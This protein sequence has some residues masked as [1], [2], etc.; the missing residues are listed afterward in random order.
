MMV[1]GWLVGGYILLAFVVANLGWLI[2]LGR[3]LGG[4][5]PAIRLLVW[6]VGLL[7]MA[8]LGRLLEARVT[9]SV[10][11]QGWEFYAVGALLFATFALPGFIYRVVIRR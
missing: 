6:L 7:A 10:A 1:P 8:G 5:R 11:E 9:G 3:R 2:P 4:W